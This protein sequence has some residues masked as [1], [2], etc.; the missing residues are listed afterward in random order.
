MT[1]QNANY[2]LSKHVRLYSHHN[3]TIT[4]VISH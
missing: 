3:K 1:T 4:I 2:N